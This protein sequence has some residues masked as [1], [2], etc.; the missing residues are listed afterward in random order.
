MDEKYLFTK[1]D[2]IEERLNSIDVTLERNTVSLEHHIYRT[3]QNEEMITLIKDDLKPV[4][5][6]IA[7]LQGVVKAITITSISLG[8]VV[9]ILKILGVL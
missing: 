4:K 7:N 8:I 1:L 5:A 9:S 6:H 3:S 2:K